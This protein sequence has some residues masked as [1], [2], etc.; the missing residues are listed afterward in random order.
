MNCDQFT[1]SIS[2]NCYPFEDKAWVVWEF[3][4]GPYLQEREPVA[5]N[6][7]RTRRIVLDSSYALIPEGG[8]DPGSALRRYSK[9]ADIDLRLFITPISQVTFIYLVAQNL[10][11]EMKKKK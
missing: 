6:S 4:Y 3:S 8:N 9:Q 2:H 10:S 11:L 1:A 5:T 7:D